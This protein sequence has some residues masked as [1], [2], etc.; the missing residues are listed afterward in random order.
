MDPSNL[1]P[2]MDAIP[3]HW[4]WLKVLL[5]LTFVL[6]ILFMNLLL[7]GAI[8]AFWGHMGSPGKNWAS[9]DFSHRLPVMTAMTINLGV[10][11]L[12][13]LQVLYGNFIYVSSVLSAVYWLCVLVLLLVAYYCLYLYR[14][15]YQ[16]L[17]GGRL[18]LTGLVAV[19]LLVIAFFFVNNMTLMAEPQSWLAYFKK[20]FGRLINWGDSSLIPRYLHFVT[21]SVAAAGLFLALTARYKQKRG[22]ALAGAS[23]ALGMYYFS[24]AT[25]LQ[26][27]TGLW[28]LIS[29]PQGIMLQFMGGQAP[30]TA[31]FMLALAGATGTLIFGFK[32]M[33]IPSTV[34]LVSTVALMALV[35]DMVRDACLHT[36]Q[37]YGTARVTGQIGPLVLFLISFV[38]GLIAVGYMFR[39]Y[40]SAKKVG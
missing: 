28:F 23:M 1:V 34:F 13:F 30:A 7:G 15:K 17:V 24:W 22:D 16:A 29:L 21:A 12:L 37:S 27:G 18:A 19:L 32:Q 5:L 40:F 2:A 4:L 3:V 33:P 6:H 11:P 31:V 14:F 20:P 38:I 8:L 35:R 39:I 9:E 10:A 36:Y 26:V 25:A